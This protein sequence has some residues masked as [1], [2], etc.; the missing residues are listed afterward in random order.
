MPVENPKHTARKEFVISNR[1]TNSIFNGYTLIQQRIFRYMIEQADVQQCLWASIRGKRSQLTGEGNY[2]FELDM[3][4]IVH[5]NNYHQVREALNKMMQTQI[6]VYWDDTFKANPGA[7]AD[8]YRT[9]NLVAS[10]EPHEKEKKKVYVY[11]HR[12][13]ALKWIINVDRDIKTK[14]PSHFTKYDRET[15]GMWMPK[16]EDRPAQWT[17]SRCKYMQPLYL[18]MCSYAGRGGIDITVEQLRSLLQVEE[19]YKGFADMDKYILKHLQ[20]ECKRFGKYCFNY[21]K[22]KTGKTVTS[23]KLKIW[24]IKTEFNFDDA[25]LKIQSALDGANNLHYYKRITFEQRA[26]FDYLLTGKFDLDEVL[27][28]LK[29]V[30]DNIHKTRTNTGKLPNVFTYLRKSLHEKYP[31]PG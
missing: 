13:I 10:W 1:F 4:K 15:V 8:H 28:K 17:G 3:S 16:T 23:L 11:V 30:H 20:E 2:C 5:W 19:K 27:Q 31:P 29:K 12:D 14:N 7:G 22:V 9:G 26:E 6:S 18:L 24:K 21:D 25:W